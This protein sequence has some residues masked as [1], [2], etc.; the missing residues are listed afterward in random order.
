MHQAV[1]V[2]YNMN[3]GQHEANDHYLERFK[4]A[5]LTVEIAKGEN[6]FVS[7]ELIKSGASTPIEE[8]LLREKEWSK[9][10]LLLKNSDDKRF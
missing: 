10:I 4:A 2:L 7:P 5:V 3:Q 9:V 1:A 8:E 6:I